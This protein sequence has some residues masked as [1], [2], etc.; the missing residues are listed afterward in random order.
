MYKE[1][2]IYNMHICIQ[3]VHYI[4]GNK[5]IL[6]IHTCWSESIHLNSRATAPGVPVR[7]ATGERAPPTWISSG[8][9]RA[10]YRVSTMA[11]WG[12]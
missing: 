5:R 4:Y 11:R 7:A 6:Y 9:E 12:W 10:C 1:Y 8:H 3:F 2:I